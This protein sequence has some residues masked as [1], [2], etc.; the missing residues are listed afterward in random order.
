MLSGQ[1]LNVSCNAIHPDENSINT[2]TKT[3][4]KDDTNI[5]SSNDSKLF[6]VQ[7][8]PKDSGVYTCLASFD[9]LEY[10]KSFH[11]TVEGKYKANM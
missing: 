5:A 4:K 10:N 8:S 9:G 1:S 7:L 11:L 6:I 3:W 2:V